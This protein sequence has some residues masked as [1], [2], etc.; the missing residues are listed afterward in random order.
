M[1]VLN[2]TTSR[3]T[4]TSLDTYDPP[5]AHEDALITESPSVAAGVAPHPV[6]EDERGQRGLNPLSAAFAVPTVGAVPVQVPAVCQ[7]LY[8]DS[9]NNKVVL[10]LLSI[11]LKNNDGEPLVA[12]DKETWC[13]LPKN[14]FRAPNNTDLVKEIQKCKST[15]ERHDFTAKANKLGKNTD[16]ACDVDFLTSENL[17]PNEVY[18]RM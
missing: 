8:V 12:F 4:M 11:G 17:R 7:H 10:Y 16:E 18:D 2:T 9:G 3:Y 5:P 13:S 1:L 6:D 14:R 15:I